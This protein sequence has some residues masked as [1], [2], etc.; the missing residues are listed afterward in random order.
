M[1][2]GFRIKTRFHCETQ[3]LYLHKYI[4]WNTSFRWATSPWAV[5]ANA[6]GMAQDMEAHADTVQDMKT[7]AEEFGE[8]GTWCFLVSME[9]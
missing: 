6:R 2:T 8:I 3:V 5:F 7:E 4:D 1:K 9:S